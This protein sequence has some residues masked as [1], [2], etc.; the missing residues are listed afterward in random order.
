MSHYFSSAHAI[1][2]CDETTGHAVRDVAFCIDAEHAELFAKTC[3]C[4]DELLAAL[5]RMCNLYSFI[6]PADDPKSDAE[7]QAEAAIAKVTKE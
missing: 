1:H 5:I 2:V 7:K 6:K 3:N 4:H